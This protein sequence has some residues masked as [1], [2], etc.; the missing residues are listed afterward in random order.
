VGVA[1]PGEG[2]AELVDL[3]LGQNGADAVST[4]P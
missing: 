1:Q 4:R 3:A 2:L